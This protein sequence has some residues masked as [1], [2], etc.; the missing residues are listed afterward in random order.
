MNKKFFTLMAA[1][2]VTGSVAA[3]NYD[4]GTD[5][6][7][8]LGTTGYTNIVGSGANNP[9]LDPSSSPLAT[10]TGAE[11]NKNVMKI[12]SDYWYQLEVNDPSTPAADVLIQERDEETGKI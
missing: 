3:Q 4:A 11:W 9:T 6:V 1:A 7:Y 5:F 8:R 12:N 2:L 10:V